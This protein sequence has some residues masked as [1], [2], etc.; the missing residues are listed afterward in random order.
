MKT[1][2]WGHAKTNPRTEASPEITDSPPPFSGIPFVAGASASRLREEG[3]FRRPPLAKLGVG[4]RSFAGST[5]D[6]CVEEAWLGRAA[7]GGLVALGTADGPQ[8]ILNGEFLK[9]QIDVTTT[10][11]TIPIPIPITTTI[12]QLAKLSFNHSIGRTHS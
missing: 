10:T 11:T 12:T 6:C 4:A 8:G 5:E 9:I 3:T 2:Q 7:T 1:Q